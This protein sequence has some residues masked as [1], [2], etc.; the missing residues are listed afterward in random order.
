M[1]DELEN[2]VLPGPDLITADAYEEIAVLD[3]G[4]GSRTPGD[5]IG[6][7]RP[8]PRHADHEHQP[9]D[10]K[11][12]DNIEERPHEDDEEALPDR[13]EV[14]LVLKLLLLHLA[15]GAVKHLHIAAERDQRNRPVG[16]AAVLKGAEHLA[17]A[18]REA[19]HLHAA[20]PCGDEMSV[21]MYSYQD[22]YREK[23]TEHRPDN[24]P[25]RAHNHQ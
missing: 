11:G 19:Q 3:P 5:N 21:L 2:G 16:A 13:L 8:E 12:K 10:G 23:E 25:G 22:G 17:E 6:H 7:G 14:E 4:S 15:L 1:L 18:K 20:E 24:V 9:V